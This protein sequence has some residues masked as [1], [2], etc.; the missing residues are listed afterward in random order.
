MESGNEKSVSANFGRI[1]V[2]F[3]Y[4]S[5]I[6]RTLHVRYVLSLADVNDPRLEKV[7]QEGETRVYEI[8]GE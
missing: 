6:A 2:P 1:I 4:Q 5:P 3:N 8:K 7:F